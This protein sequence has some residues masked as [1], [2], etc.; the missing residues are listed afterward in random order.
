MRAS[1]RMI[2]YLKTLIEKCEDLNIE[3]PV[4]IR[5]TSKDLSPD[6]DKVSDA[7]DDLKFELGWE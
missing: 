3:V 5:D 4:E 1:L 7:I 2:Q 6:F